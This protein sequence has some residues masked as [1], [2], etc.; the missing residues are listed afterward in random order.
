MLARDLT[1][2]D[3]VSGGAASC[4]SAARS[5]T[6][7]GRGVALCRALWREGAVASEGP[8]TSRCTL[9]PPGRDR[10]A[11]RARSSRW[12][13]PTGDRCRRVPRPGR[14]PS[15]ARRQTRVSARWSGCDRYGHRA[16]A[17]RGRHA[18]DRGH[19]PASPRTQRPARRGR[20]R[21]R[22]VPPPARVGV[23]WLSRGRPVLRPLRLPHHDAPARGVGRD[24]AASTWPPSG[25]DG[26]GGSCPRCSSSS[27]RSPSISSATRSS[28][29]PARTALIDLSGLRGDAIGTLLYANNWHLIYAHQS[30]FAQFSTPSPLQHTWS[31]AIEEQF[32]LV[33]PLVLLSCCATP[34]AAGARWE[35][36]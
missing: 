14:P 21:R 29:A 1:S 26:P 6:T 16:G 3:L 28:A 31:L 34:G 33:W 10:R 13:S 11:R 7:S 36:S 15:P 19:R 9:P 17:P 25:G 12:T 5:P 22:G 8:A 30:Y 32:Y 24:R 35:S 2:L 27:S 23:G 4:A 18:D 20:H